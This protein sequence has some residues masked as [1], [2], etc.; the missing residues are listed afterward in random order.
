MQVSDLIVRANEVETFVY[1]GLEG[2]Y[3]SQCLVDDT[4]VGST[5]LNLNRGVLKPGKHLEGGSHPAGYDE[6]YYIISGRGRLALGGD[7]Q[8]GE[9]SEVFEVEPENAVFIPGGTFHALENP[10]D[11]DLVIITIW[12]RL[13]EPGAN[14]IYDARKAAWGTSFRLKSR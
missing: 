5:N 14:G 7:P 1:P 9:G 10:Y 3:D 11:T 6:C 8:T 4:S 2:I 13:P 12:P